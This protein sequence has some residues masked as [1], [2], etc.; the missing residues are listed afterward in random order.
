VIGVYQ[1]E[2][3]DLS[4]KREMLGFLCL[5]ALGGF[6]TGIVTSLAWQNFSQSRFQ[7]DALLLWSLI[8]LIVGGLLWILVYFLFGTK[9][10]LTQG[11][12]IG[13]GF[14]LTVV[15]ILFWQIKV[16]MAKNI[17]W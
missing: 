16:Q 10:I 15:F 5:G 17:H 14:G 1:Q 7:V 12:R 3:G 8:G 6:L 4:G 2:V 13:F 11:T 9:F